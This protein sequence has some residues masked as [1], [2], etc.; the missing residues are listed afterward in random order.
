MHDV[1]WYSRVITKWVTSDNNFLWY[2][3]CVWRCSM[4]TFLFMLDDKCLCNISFLFIFCLSNI[5]KMNSL[6]L[7]KYC[8]LSSQNG[9]S[10]S[11]GGRSMWENAWHIA[12][13]RIHGKAFS[14]TSEIYFHT[15]FSSTS[16]TISRKIIEFMG[17]T[18]PFEWVNAMDARNLV[19]GMRSED[20]LVSRSH[21]FPTKMTGASNLG[22]GGRN[23]TPREIMSPPHPLTLSPRVWSTPMNEGVH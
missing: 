20:L 2:R 23:N 15:P 19:S 11:N 22:K 17:I 9:S 6:I 10:A 13:N 14:N 1:F 16:T 4:L 12:A 7:Y 3:G 18:T 8:V 5:S 21:L